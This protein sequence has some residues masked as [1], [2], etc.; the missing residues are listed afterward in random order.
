MK[1]WTLGLLALTIFIY[2]V[3]QVTIEGMVRKMMGS[4]IMLVIYCRNFPEYLLFSHNTNN[5]N[6]SDSFLTTKGYLSK[7]KMAAATLGFLIM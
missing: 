2:A 3:L 6:V 4:E 5:R 1:K 7:R